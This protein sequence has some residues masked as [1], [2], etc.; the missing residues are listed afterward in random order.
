MPRDRRPAAF[1]AAFLGLFF[2]A[3]LAILITAIGFRTANGRAL[4]LA[5]GSSTLMVRACSTSCALLHR[6]PGSLR[7]VDHLTEPSTGRPLH[8][9]S[10]SHDLPITNL[11]ASL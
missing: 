5:P 3:F 6:Q 7:L 10:R 4:A 1:F 8:V 2:L 9:L 11:A